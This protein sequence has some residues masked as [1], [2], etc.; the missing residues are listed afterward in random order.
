M[1]STRELRNIQNVQVHLVFHHLEEYIEQEGMAMGL[2][3]E[4]TGESLHADFYKTWLH[5]L[6]KED[7]AKSYANNLLSVAVSYNSSHI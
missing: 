4:Q 2:F 7:S 3:S 1:I 5:Y 6:V